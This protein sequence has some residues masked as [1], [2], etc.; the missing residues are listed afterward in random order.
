VKALAAATAA[1]LALAPALA[2]AGG[3]FKVRG[4]IL[5]GG[6]VKVGEDRFR[7]PGNWEATFRFLKTAYPADRYPR[8]FIVNQP[9][10]KAVHVVNRNA[11]EEWEG[12]NVYEIQTETGREVRLFIL[13]RREPA[14]EPATA[15]PATPA[16]P[17]N[18]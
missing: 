8:K 11:K 5:P 6:S 1:A 18:P 9:S 10:V 16:P 13:A 3:E 4:V 12:M 7:M 14:P 15:P 17:S 2:R